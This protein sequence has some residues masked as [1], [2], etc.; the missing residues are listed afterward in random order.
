VT[1]L[2]AAKHL[3]DLELKREIGRGR[4]R[5]KRVRVGVMLEVP[6]LLWQLDNLLPKVDF[7]SIGSNDLLQFLYAA[8]R[9]NPRLTD[10]YDTL[11]PAVLRV[12][13]DVVRRCAKAKVPLSLCGEMAGKPLDAMALAALGLR[14]LSMNPVSV[15][16]VKA[17]VR[18]LDLARLQRFLADQMDRDERSL[19][20][21]IRS[22]A[23]DNGILI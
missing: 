20:E 22:Y 23:V 7:V 15:G 19:R 16:P 9:G 4:K 13:A 1:E 18:S 14:T 17:M 10:R 8:D 11:A 6:A 3:L 2:D 12:F 5:P 21:I